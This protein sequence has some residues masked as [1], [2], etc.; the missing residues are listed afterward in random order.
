MAQHTLADLKNVGSE[1]SVLYVEDEAMLR[2]G[3]LGSLRQLFGN[4]EV[5]ED[6]AVGLELYRHADFDLVLTDISMPN[7]DGITMIRRIKEQNPTA[8]II[9]ISA[10]ND[11]D[12]LLELINLGVDRFLTKPISKIALIEALYSISSAITSIKQAETY[13][14]QLE[15]KARLLNTFIKKEYL[16]NKIAA[17]PE[18]AA[19][20]EEEERPFE[21]YF[22]HILREELDELIDLNEELDYDILLAFQNNR[23]DPAYVL[24]LSK[25]YERYGVILNRHPVFSEIGLSLHS[26][27]REFE[28]HQQAF[29][30]QLSSIRELLESFNF[31]LITFRKNI[32]ETKSAHPT[33]YNPS[34]LSDIA[35]IRNLLKQTEIHGDIEF[36]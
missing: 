32:L 26:L 34:L 8:R 20:K 28:T 29:I 22:S 17:S 33:F 19:G 30:D 35:M 11:T 16:R 13:R 6:G 24:R 5:A 9:V 36:F 12:K 14:T 31:T 2:D 3:L 7:M 18:Q 25:R 23:V 21:D 1:L 27:S 15:Q 10:Q 4:V